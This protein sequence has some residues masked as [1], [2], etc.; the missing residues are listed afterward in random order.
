MHYARHAQL[1]T[2]IVCS[3]KVICS[4]KIICLLRG[5]LCRLF[6]G[7]RPARPQQRASGGGPLLWPLLY[8]YSWYAVGPTH[9]QLSSAQQCSCL[10]M[11]QQVGLDEEEVVRLCV[12]RVVCAVCATSEPSADAMMLSVWQAGRALSG[13]KTREMDCCYR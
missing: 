3:Q 11:T 6:V 10:Y 7:G 2:G 13:L 12:Q 8:F 5:V 1:D 4:Q 9:P